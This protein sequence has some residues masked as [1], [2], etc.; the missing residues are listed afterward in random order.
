MPCMAWPSSRT[1]GRSTPT[2]RTSG[3]SSSPIPGDRSTSS[4]S[5]ASATGSPTSLHEQR[6]VRRR[7][8]P[9]G[10]RWGP[11]WAWPGERPE[12]WPTDEPW[13]PSRRRGPW[14]RFGC[15]IAL[16]FLLGIVAVIGA[17]TSLVATVFAEPGSAGQGARIAAFLVVVVVL[18]VLGRTWAAVHR[19]GRV[20]DDIVEQASRVEAGDYSARVELRRRAPGAVRDLVRGFNTMA[21][22]LDAD[23]R[24]RRSLLADVTHELRTPLTI[25]SGNVEAILDGVHPADEAHLTA[26]LDET[27]VMSR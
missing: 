24:Q 1:N 8:P 22:R 16:V 13:P 27:R 15:L 17:I 3:A 10:A 5:T 14:R 9:A 18:A 6:S 7:R 12:W 20:L 26:I 11:P 2:S 19:S 25:I 21:E 23:E 4:P